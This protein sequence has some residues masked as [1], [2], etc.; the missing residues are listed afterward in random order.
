M[1]AAIESQEFWQQHIDKLKLSSL[2]R[3]QYCRDNELNYDRFGYWLKSAFI[4]VKVKATE[5]T[6][7]D[8]TLCTL[9]FRGCLLKIHDL[10]ALSFVL[11]RMA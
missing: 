1:K 11:E 9:E 4:P 7:T 3:A 10:S 5:M 2:S 8:V 6:M